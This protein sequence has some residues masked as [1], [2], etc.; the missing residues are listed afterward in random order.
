MASDAI[1]ITAT[2]QIP[3]SELIERFSTSGGPGGQHANRAATRVDL[4]FDV[5]ASEA[6][7]PADKQRIVERLGP[8]VRIVAE[9]ERSQYRNRRLA[10]E[11][12]VTTLAEALR[13]RRSRRP[14]RRT[15]G[16]Q[17]RRLQAKRQRSD[18]KAARRRPRHDD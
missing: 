11:R 3:R 18:T 15:R 1:R 12:L 4:V 9:D 6:L 2:V 7:R 17:E 8:V 16:S 10:E 5:T 13:V 14:T